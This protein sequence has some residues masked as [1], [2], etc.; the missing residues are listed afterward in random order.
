MVAQHGDE[1]FHAS[2]A[3]GTDNLVVVVQDVLALRVGKAVHLALL[4]IVVDVVGKQHQVVDEQMTVLGLE[5]KHVERVGVVHLNPHIDLLAGRVVGGHRRLESHVLHKVN[6]PFL[7]H[8]HAAGGGAGLQGKKIS[9][10][11]LVAKG[12]QRNVQAA[13]TGLFG[14]DGYLSVIL[15]SHQL[16]GEQLEAR[17][18]LFVVLSQVFGIKGNLDLD[19]CSSGSREREDNRTGNLLTADLHHLGGLVGREV[20]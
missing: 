8:L 10:L 15:D 1:H 11:L 7:R 6:H 19:I 16:G 12:A 17:S 5:L 9:L 14:L 3:E 2:F 20:S 4:C 18:V 13:G